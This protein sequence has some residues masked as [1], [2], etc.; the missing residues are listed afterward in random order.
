MFDVW[1]PK[2]PIDGRYLWLPVRFE[3]GRILV[4]HPQSWRVSDL[5]SVTDIMDR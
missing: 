4:S 3:S 2:N 1:R 5:D